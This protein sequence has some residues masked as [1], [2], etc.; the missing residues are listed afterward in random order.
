M[1][2]RLVMGLIDSWWRCTVPY[3]RGD[4]IPRLR[5]VARSRPRSGQALWARADT[6]SVVIAIDFAAEA[7][8]VVK[9]KRRSVALDHLKPD[10]GGAVGLAPTHET[11]GERATEAAAALL[12]RGDDGV[13]A[14]KLALPHRETGGDRDG[15]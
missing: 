6:G 7:E 13:Q 2:A 4:R 9:A 10:E 15:A 14:E 1:A 8:R 3:F 5:C 12:R 11:T